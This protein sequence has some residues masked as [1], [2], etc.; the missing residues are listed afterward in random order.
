MYNTLSKRLVIYTRLKITHSDDLIT[1]ETLNFKV[2]FDV[3]DDEK[4]LNLGK[5]TWSS[6][7]SLTLKS[8]SLT[9]EGLWTT[10]LGL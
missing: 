2:A 4:I 10:F 6:I 3:L 8:V 5:N 7:L 1:K 9:K